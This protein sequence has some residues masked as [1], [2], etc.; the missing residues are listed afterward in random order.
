[1]KKKLWK[2]LKFSTLEIKSQ[3]YNI[4]PGVLKISAPT[5]KIENLG[6][7][8]TISSG[9][10]LAKG[11][12]FET[13]KLNAS[14]EFTVEISNFKI[15]TTTLEKGKVTGSFLNQN[16]KIEGVDYSTSEKDKISASSAAWNGK[17][18]TKDGSITFNNPSISNAEGF[19]FT[20]AVGT[21]NEL[22]FGN[23]VKSRDIEIHLIK[24][25]K[26][27]IISLEHLMLQPKLVSWRVCKANLAGLFTLKRDANKVYNYKIE[28]GNYHG[29]F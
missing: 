10:S 13:A 3:N 20:T 17:I 25:G 29:N 15:A 8:I 9:I 27:D 2:K 4:I 26:I 24:E 5:L 21:L 18:L 1:M 28:N 6:K 16:F 14:G 23:F 11:V 12:N 19:T 22:N 7:K